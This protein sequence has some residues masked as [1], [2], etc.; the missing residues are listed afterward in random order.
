MPW[1]PGSSGTTGVLESGSGNAGC[2]YATGEI[3]YSGPGREC[4]GT[5][6]T[7]DTDKATMGIAWDDGDGVITYPLDAEYL[8]K[9]LPWE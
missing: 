2:R 9:A 5:V 7:V 3:V 8:R 4:R 1:E 6:V